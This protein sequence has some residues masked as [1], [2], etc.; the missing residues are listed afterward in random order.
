MVCGATPGKL[1]ESGIY[2]FG[3]TVAYQIMNVYAVKMGS[4]FDGLYPSCSLETIGS[5]Y[6][7]SP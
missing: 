3:R 7:I 4:G 5:H 2:T 1:M 6:S